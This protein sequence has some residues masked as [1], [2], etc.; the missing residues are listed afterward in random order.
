M[1]MCTGFLLCKAVFNWYAFLLTAKMIY[2]K[3]AFTNSQALQINY[4]DMS[5]PPAVC[6]GL[7][8]S[9]TYEQS[10][11]QKAAQKQRYQKITV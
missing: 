11:D 5:Q 6:Y 1:E 4:N 2:M 10:Q 8:L 7:Y 3:P 9:Y